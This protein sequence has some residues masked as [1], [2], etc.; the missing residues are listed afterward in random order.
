[1]GDASLTPRERF[2]SRS[3]PVLGLLPPR[4]QRMLSGRRTVRID[5]QELDAGV[6]LI[7]RVLALRGRPSL[8]AGLGRDPA[9]IRSVTH[10]EAMV[11][12]RRRTPVKSV[13]EIEIDGGAGPRRARHYAPPE[14]GGPHPL[15]VFVHGGGWCVGD[16]DTHDEPCR[17]LCRHAGIHVLSIDYRLAPE[18]PFPAGLDD[19]VAALRWAHEN[20][21]R[22]G[23]DPRRI[24]IGGDSAGGNLSTAASLLA[25]GGAGVSPALQVLIY[26]ATDFV[27]RRRSIELFGTGFFLTNED[28]AWCEGN[29]VGAID[30]DLSDPRISPFRAPDLSGVAPAI[31]MT[32][33]FDPLRDE[34]EDYA[35]ALRAA[36][37]QVAV[38]RAPGLI[39]GFINMTM[40]NRAARESVI[41][42]AG[43][44]RA[45]L[46]EPPARP[47]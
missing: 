25:A 5:G 33:A 3:G 42:L 20:A 45:A 40:V 41:T 1:M 47:A 4:A 9:H 13:S 28:R 29:Y 30:A 35:A 36:G 18:D 24:A 46:T 6:Q 8:T 37:V 11:F 16:L 32:A 19:T 10:R 34:G 2:E 12:A 15:L 17:L 21:E 7:L 38:H 43:M 31:V 23:A 26:P 14:A 39:H 22:L 44:I 27:E